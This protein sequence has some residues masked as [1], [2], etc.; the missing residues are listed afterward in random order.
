MFIK[1]YILLNNNI[2]SDFAIKD[3]ENITGVK[4]HTIRIWE[5][6]YDL[7]QPKRTSGNA[8][9]YSHKSL[10]KLL[11]VVLLN[12]NGLKISKI[13]L[14]SDDEIILKARELALH[15]GINNKAIDSLKVSMF[16]FDVR[17]F[18]LTYNELLMRKSFREIFKDVF[19]PFLEHIGL[20]WQTDTLTP[21]HEHFI[22]NLIA[23]KIH[24][25]TEKLLLN[26]PV[27][28]D[29][30]YI[31]YLPE[32]EIHELGLLYIN[33]ELA[34]RG[35]KTIYL[36]Q[37]VPLSNLNKLMGLFNRITFITSITVAPIEAKVMAYL[38][39]VTKLLNMEEHEFVCI[40]R[41]TTDIDASVFPK[42]F[43]FFINTFSFIESI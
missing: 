30:A 19:A 20:L 35:Y 29:K 2:K 11:N 8:R 12:N 1:N 32:N 21:A 36:G 41:H 24:L 16:Q 14:L 5:K 26:T 15:S 38:D 25:N 33:Y 27:N 28:V 34:L 6:R 4:A 9:Y 13:A 31:L 10:Q 3:L 40:S 37:S 22:S 7:L 39:E 23:Q 17:L 43:S 42:N 18:N